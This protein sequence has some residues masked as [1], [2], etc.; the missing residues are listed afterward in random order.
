[1]FIFNRAAYTDSHEFT[2]SEVPISVDF[3]TI[4]VKF[5]AHESAPA[6]SSELLAG[7]GRVH[8]RGECCGDCQVI[9][10]GASAHLGGLLLRVARLRG[11]E[12]EP[13]T[14]LARLNAEHE[15][16]EPSSV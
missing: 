5:S 1:M 2:L 4:S 13:N 10:R 7:D 11:R 6:A 15:R 8:V 12:R 16:A 14:D 3:S 9:R